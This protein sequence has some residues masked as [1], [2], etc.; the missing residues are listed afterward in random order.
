MAV[1]FDLERLEVIG[2]P[3]PVVE[4]VMVKTN[5][6]ANFDLSENG[7]LVYVAGSTEEVRESAVWVEWDGSEESL[8]L[9]SRNY[10][11]PRLSPDGTRLATGVLDSGGGLALWVFD[12]ASAAGLR[13]TQEGTVNTPV[14]TSDNRIAFRVGGVAAPGI[15]TVMADGS[16]EPE[17][18]L[19][20]EEGT[21]GDFPTGATPD[22]RSLIFTR[23]RDGSRRDILQVPLEGEPV[24]EPVLAGEFSRGNGE[25]SPDGRWLLYRSD[26]SGQMEIYVQPYP[27]PGPTIPVS[28][29]G[30]T[31]PTWSPDGSDVIYRLDDRMM[32]VSF[33]VDGETPRIGQPR[34]LFRG[35]Y[36]AADGQ[37]YHVSPDGRFLML[38]DVTGVTAGGGLSGQIILV[39][40]FFEELRQP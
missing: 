14:W 22:G 8:P 39:Q 35:D 12:V 37:Q 20:G 1:A 23:I 28:I 31:N 21:I 33:S 36:V 17:P 32:A 10:Q 11:A 24:A 18:L 30:G 5:G 25:V 26:Q 7:T 19:L 34:E 2:D 13:L 38:R 27:G 15:Y 16:G 40:N 9:P 29:G 4:G 6:A 3:T